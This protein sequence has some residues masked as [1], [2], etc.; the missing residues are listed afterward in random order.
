VY[1]NDF[2]YK[3]PV[4]GNRESFRYVTELGVR[5]NISSIERLAGKTYQDLYNPIFFEIES[6][7]MFAGD[8]DYQQCF[9]EVTYAIDNYCV[10]CSLKAELRQQSWRVPR[11]QRQ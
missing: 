11:G 3:M 10:I 7:D 9:L 1:R 5:S 6:L 4:P 8:P 2:G